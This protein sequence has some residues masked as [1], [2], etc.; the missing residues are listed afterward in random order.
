MSET[1]SLFANDKGGAAPASTNV[2]DMDTEKVGQDLV[3]LV[4]ALVQTLCELVEKQAIRRV[5]SGTLSEGEVERLGIALMQQEE[6][7]NELKEHFG[8]SDDDLKLHLGP[9]DDFLDGVRV[10]G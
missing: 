9:L 5:D 6:K 10:D 2:S 4:L 1:Q 7:M 8:L 3:R